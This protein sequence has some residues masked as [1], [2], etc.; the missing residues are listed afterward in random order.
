MFLPRH[1]PSFCAHA[2]HAIVAVCL[3]VGAA[4]CDSEAGTTG[5]TGSNPP[6]S[7]GSESTSAGARPSDPSTVQG[8]SEQGPGESTLIV[9]LDAPSRVGDLVDL[10]TVELSAA[11]SGDGAGAPLAVYIPDGDGESYGP[12]VVARDALATYV[13]DIVNQRVLRLANDG[14]LTEITLPM[15]VNYLRDL[16]AMVID[17]DAST[18]YLQVIDTVHA[19]GINDSREQW[20]VQVAGAAPRTLTIHD[21][22]VTV[23]T[24]SNCVTL[25]AGT[26]QVVEGGD[27]RALC[28]VPD[29]HAG[30]ARV[31]VTLSQQN[32]ASV[33][34]TTTRGTVLR[35]EIGEVDTETNTIYGT[36]DLQLDDGQTRLTAFAVNTT[37]STVMTLPHSANRR[38][39]TAMPVTDH[40]G[41]IGIWYDD[42][43][44]RVSTVAWD[45]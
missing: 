21:G 38:L 15:P 6:D 8:S 31:L 18:M 45:E 39:E 17:E 14:S 16:S 4:A 9:D 19:M 43:T 7:V 23:R 11:M 13:A 20:Q 40:A 26:G 1:R 33:T 25:A 30:A 22:V 35:V 44:I 27:A 12:S 29:V 24:G 2:L 3:M 28:V 10:M 32:I 34:L 41:T 42:T 5:S 36:A 37:S